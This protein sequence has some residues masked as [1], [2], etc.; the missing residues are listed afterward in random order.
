MK[1]KA[2]HIVLWVVGATIGISA[3][4]LVLHVEQVNSSVD[5]YIATVKPG[6]SPYA[7]LQELGYPNLIGEYRICWD[8]QEEDKGFYSSD[9]NTT[10]KTGGWKQPTKSGR[11][12]LNPAMPPVLTGGSLL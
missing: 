7:V 9:F 4:F 11:R 1:R 8:E 12:S 5:G 3:L 10:S 2:I 6:M